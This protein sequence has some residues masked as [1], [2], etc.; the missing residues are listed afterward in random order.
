[1][2]ALAAEIGWVRKDHQ[3]FRFKLTYYRKA[4]VKALVT[5]EIG[6]GG[7]ARTKNVVLTTRSHYKP[8]MEIAWEADKDQIIDPL[9][10]YRH[11][12]T[13]EMI[14]SDRYGPLDF[15]GRDMNG[16]RNGK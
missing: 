3:Q 11:P 14:G 15:V 16:L 9:V 8:G 12:D 7:L 2:L 5:E 10:W 6:A 1:L 13:N 4:H